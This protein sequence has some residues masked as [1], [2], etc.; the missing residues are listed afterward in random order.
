MSTVKTRRQGNAMMVTIPKSFHIPAGT[1]LKPILT[2]K[3]IFFE[4]VDDNDFFDFD[5][6]ILSD[7]VSEGYQGK[8]LVRRFREQKKQ[9]PSMMDHLINDAEREAS[10][11]S[12]MTKKEFEHKIGL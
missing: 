7:L 10:H 2:D 3:G 11:S 8:D 1:T 4:F 6:D 5:T 12:P 9:L